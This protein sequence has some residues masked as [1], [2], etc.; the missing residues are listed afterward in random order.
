MHLTTNN[1]KKETNAK[2]FYTH[3]LSTQYLGIGV[4]VI[5][6][7]TD[8]L[9]TTFSFTL[10]D[11]R[12]Y[13]VKKLDEGGIYDL[14]YNII[15]KE[16]KCIMQKRKLFKTDYIV[17]IDIPQFIRDNNK[18]KNC[19]I[20]LYTY[21]HK[22]FEFEHKNRNNQKEIIELNSIIKDLKTIIELVIEQTNEYIKKN[23]N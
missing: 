10:N 6:R 4:E 17:I 23:Y 8:T 15:K 12:H 18:N 22:R 16:C 13:N 11:N 3:Y 9:I 1:M 2:H 5:K 20:E 14:F 19:K 21:L 7:K